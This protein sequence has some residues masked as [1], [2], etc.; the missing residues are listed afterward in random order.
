MVNRAAL[1]GLRSRRLW[2][3]VGNTQHIWRKT[4]STFTKFK[5]CIQVSY[6]TA[7]KF[8][9]QTAPF[10]LFGEFNAPVLKIFHVPE[11]CHVD[12]KEKI[13]NINK[14]YVGKNKP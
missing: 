5:V 9:L 3:T 12:S 2:Q 7:R 1:S 10:I 13:G 11:I 8:S 14:I 4:Y 6:N